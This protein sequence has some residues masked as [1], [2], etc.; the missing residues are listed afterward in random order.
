MTANKKDKV[1]KMRVEQSLMNRWIKFFLIVTEIGG[2]FTGFV[3]LLRE[4]PWN[5]N[6]PLNMR[7]FS[8]LFGILYI[9][10]IIAGLTLVEWPRR[11][12]QLSLVYQTLQIPVISSPMLTYVFVSGLRLIAGWRG[13]S[14]FILYEVGSRIVLHVMPKDPW[15]VG[16]NVLAL[17]LFVYLLFHLRP[18]VKAT[19]SSSTIINSQQGDKEVRETRDSHLFMFDTS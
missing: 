8:T 16:I 9:F 6:I 17:A 3:V 11:G 15:M 19:E 2:G 1:N 7:I 14:I 4:S 18:K 13:G 5:A 12:I 10:G